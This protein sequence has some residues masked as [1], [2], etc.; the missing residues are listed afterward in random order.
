MT[1]IQT[2]TSVHT[3][4]PPVNREP[5]K[6]ERLLRIA[7]EMERGF[8]FAETFDEARVITVY[9]SARTAPEDPYYQKAYELGRLLAQD[10]HSIAVTTGGGPGI[11]E[12]SNKGAFEA[13]GISVGLGIQLEHIVETPNPY[14]THRMDFYY[15]FAR[16]VILAHIAQGYVYFPGGFGTMD[17]FFELST[18]VATKKIETPPT[19]ILMGSDYWNGLFDWLRRGPI[20]KYRTMSEEFLSVYTITDSPEEA[21]RLLDKIPDRI[22]RSDVV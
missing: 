22:E 2:Q 14:T 4:Q 15:F 19:I 18:L 21:Y 9:G 10:N 1:Q 17:E 12:A 5:G 20:E 7:D 6:R 8:R 16:K 11:M 13:N 3:S